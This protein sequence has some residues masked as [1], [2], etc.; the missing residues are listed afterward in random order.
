M[1]NK[2]DNALLITNTFYFLLFDGPVFENAKDN[3][4]LNNIFTNINNNNYCT[5]TIHHKIITSFNFDLG[6]L[7][8]NKMLKSIT[9]Q[10][11]I[12]S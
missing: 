7:T 1:L 5:I 4:C 6:K 3:S 11:Q 9:G 12:A 10:E 2:L 8:P